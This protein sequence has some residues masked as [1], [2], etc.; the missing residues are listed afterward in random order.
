MPDVI[1]TRF[2]GFSDLYHDVR[3]RPPEKV[4]RILL[5]WLK[6][7]RAETVV[8]LGCG[9]GLST[10]IWLPFAARVIGIE[11]NGDMRRTAETAVP[12]AFFAA[13]SSYATGLPDHSVDIVTCSQ[14]FHWMEPAA[15]L[16]EAAR[17]LHPGGIFAV[18]DCAWPVTVGVG[19]ERA[20]VKF[21]EG[22]KALCASRRDELP[23]EPKFP[24]NAHEGNI[25][26]SGRFAYCKK[27]LFD[28]EEPC[29]AER[30][31]GIAL[32]QGDVQT[33]RKAGV[34]ELAPLISEFKAAVRADLRR[35]ATMFVSYELIAAVTF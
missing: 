15:T 12:G 1:T 30:F 18:Y 25:V 33:L 7:G 21:D 16:A 4:C 3:P 29:D 27:I 34:A 5:Q 28:N 19:A 23:A 6:S 17:I 8:D 14:S 26:A 24:K 9:T 11:P 31:I 13:G 2:T 20:F 32:S 22:I 35:P 10:G